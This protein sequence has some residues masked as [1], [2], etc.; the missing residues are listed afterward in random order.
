MSS[1][2]AYRCPTLPC[3][4]CPSSRPLRHSPARTG[5]TT[6]SSPMWRARPLR[7]SPAAA[8]IPCRDR[9]AAARADVR[10]VDHS[11]VETR[12]AQHS[13][14]DRESAD[15]PSPRNELLQ[16]RWPTVGF[17]HAERRLLPKPSAPQH[18]PAPRVVV[19]H[20]VPPPAASV[21]IVSIALAG[22]DAR[23]R[24]G[25]PR[26]ASRARHGQCGD[27][28][29][30]SS[31]RSARRERRERGKLQGFRSV[32]GT[33]HY[34]TR[35][36]QRCGRHIVGD[37]IDMRAWPMP[38]ARRRRTSAR[39]AACVDQSLYH[40]ETMASRK[41]ATPKRPRKTTRAKASVDPP[42]PRAQRPR[43][44]HPPRPLPPSPP[45]PGPQPPRPRSASPRSR[46]R[47]STRPSRAT[48]RRIVYVHGIGNKPPAS[49]LKAQ[50]DQALFEFD[51]GERSRMA[52]WVDRERYPVPLNDV[53][54]GGDYADGSENAPTGEFSPRAVRADVESGRGDGRRIERRHQRAR[55]APTHAPPRRATRHACA[56]RRQD[57]RRDATRERSRVRGCAEELQGEKGEH[58]RRIQ[59]QRYGAAALQ[60][61]IFN[62]L[63]RPM[64]QWLTR[65]VTKMF[66]R[67]VND[68]FVDK[69]K[70]NADARVAPR[71]AARRQRAVRRRGAQPGDDDRVLRAH[72]A[73]VR[74]QDIALFVTRRLAARHRRG[75][76]LHQGAHRPAAAR[77]SAERAAVDQRLRSA[78]S[79]RARQGSRRRVHGEREGRVG[80]RIT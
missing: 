27:Q 61:K 31:T 13:A 41:R 59:A 17:A 5:T 7:A 47:R 46:M 33:K 38:F 65:N 39:D 11:A 53:S 4:S 15:A 29:C 20:V 62:F 48:R 51:L 43:R 12:V 36:F 24:L 9:S 58:V 55:G 14:V 74:G 22:R 1:R 3:G 75:A 49:V 37:V 45:P 52:Y 50:W 66:L 72:G 76:G 77:R 79:R 32:D 80:S 25:L 54:L 35:H 63:P 60:A 30:D 28:H 64:R 56:H 26:C 23:R 18:Q 68:L 71:A 67:D 42:E 21:A 57:A 69:A 78:R 8:D 19:R 73:G 10:G 44:P 34:R 70:G 2:C 6:L 40:A 16:R